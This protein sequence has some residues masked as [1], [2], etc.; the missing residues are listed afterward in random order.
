[1][2]YQQTLNITQKKVLLSH[3]QWLVTYG[4]PLIPMLVR[5]FAEKIYGTHFGKN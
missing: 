5:N 1:M 2:E 4:I 3:I